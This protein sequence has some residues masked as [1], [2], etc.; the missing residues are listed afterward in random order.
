MLLMDLIYIVVS[1]TGLSGQRQEF[2][3]PADRPVHHDP[4]H[5]SAVFC[6]CRR[7]VVKNHRFAAD[8]GAGII[9]L[10]N[11][12]MDERQSDPRGRLLGVLLAAG[13]SWPFV[14]VMFPADQFPGLRHLAA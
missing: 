9:R 7:S 14:D 13:Y 10:C 3:Q 5:V 6:L 12:Q 4:Q 2:E 1:N 11:W 8:V